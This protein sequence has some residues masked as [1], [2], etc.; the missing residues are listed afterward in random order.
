MASLVVMLALGGKVVGALAVLL[1]IGNLVESSVLHLVGRFVGDSAIA[2]YHPLDVTLSRRLLRLVTGTLIVAAIVIL[3]LPEATFSTQRLPA[4][5]GLAI[6][7]FLIAAVIFVW[8]HWLTFLRNSPNASRLL[9]EYL[10]SPFRRLKLW[11]AAVVLTIVAF[12]VLDQGLPWAFREARAL[13]YRVEARL[14]VLMTAAALSELE[15]RIS[16]DIRVADLG[17][18][19]GE[20]C[21]Q[22]GIELVGWLRSLPE[23]STASIAELSADYSAS[24]ADE[25]GRSLMYAVSVTLALSCAAVVMSPVALLGVR[26][27]RSVLMAAA[28]LL[29]LPT[30]F[31]LDR[32]GVTSSLPWLWVAVYAPF[33]V[34]DATISMNVPLTGQPGF[35]I[36]GRMALHSTVE[37]PNL[38]AV[39][40]A[41]I[42]S[43]DWGSMI[44]LGFSRCKRCTRA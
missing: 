9:T 41:R 37:C 11:V 19:E 15:R 20:R 1:L 44:R 43:A 8:R 36:D 25:I 33:A 29:P 23:R 42:R 12:V 35:W 24:R 27:R 31:V 30:L 32:M 38:R 5:V 22:A 6:I 16:T 4:L 40:R 14:N 7:T 17:I 28:A 10:G 3:A 26:G 21:R 2:G 34:S 39:S 13:P 18:A